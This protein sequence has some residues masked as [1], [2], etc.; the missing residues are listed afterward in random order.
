MDTF[1]RVFLAILFLF[2]AIACVAGIVAY[3]NTPLLH[4]IQTLSFFLLISAFVQRNLPLVIFG[5]ILLLALGTLLGIL[6]LRGQFLGTARTI[7]GGAYEPWS[8]HGPGV[9][10]VDYGV[11]GKAVDS[12]IERI[13]GVVQSR[14][15]IYSDEEGILAQTSLMVRRG[16]DFHEVD[17]A[18]RHAINRAWL[19]RMGVELVRHDILISVEQAERRVV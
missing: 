18:I 15:R 16:V 10:D 12:V 8:A 3:Y 9:T 4:R 2:V 19:D 13:H 7:A 11:I 5:A 14:T 17:N 6:W 1:N